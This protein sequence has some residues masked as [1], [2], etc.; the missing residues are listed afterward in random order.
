V[1][2]TLSFG[3]EGTCGDGARGR[4]SNPPVENAIAPAGEVRSSTDSALARIVVGKVAR[5]YWRSTSPSKID[6]DNA[7]FMGALAPSTQPVPDQQPLIDITEV[8]AAV[9][10]CI[11]VVGNDLASLSIDLFDWRN[12][13]KPVKI[14][15]HAAIELWRHIN[16][17]WTPALFF[18]HWIGD[19][20]TCGEA[21]SFFD[22]ENGVPFNVLRM[23]PQRVVVVPDPV[24]MIRGYLYRDMQYNSFPFLPEEIMH[25]RTANLNSPF[26]GLPPIG[27]LRHALLLEQEMHGFQYNRFKQGIPTDM[28][29]ETTRQWADEDE[30]EKFARKVQQRFAGAHNAGKPMVFTKG[31][32]DITLLPR[33][34]DKELAFLASLKF[35]RSE[36]AMLYG[37]PPVKLS[38]YSDAFRANSETQERSY[39]E[40]TVRSWARMLEEWWNSIYLKRF[41]PNE[42][43]RLKFNFDQVRALQQS[44]NEIA[45]FNTKGVQ[46]GWLSPNEARK[47]AGLEAWADKVADQLYYNGRKLG[48][49]PLAGVA[50]KLLQQ[51]D[52]EDDDSEQIQDQDSE[53]IQDQQA[54]RKLRLLTGKRS[55]LDKILDDKAETARLAARVRRLLREMYRVAGEEL[56][57]IAGIASA[58]FRVTDPTVLLYIERQSINLAGHWTE[59]T[60]EKLRAVLGEGVAT[61]KGIVQMRDNLQKAFEERREDWQLDRIARTETHEAHEAA[62]W[63]AAK[64]NEIPF[65]QWTTARDDRVRD[66]H[67]ALE[68]QIV[69]MD[70]SFADPDTGA[71]YMFPGDATL[72][73]GPEDIINCRCVWVAN[74]ESDDGERAVSDTKAEAAW[75]RAI[76]TLEV[77]EQSMRLLF[78][79]HTQEMERRVLTAFDE[80]AAVEA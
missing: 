28:V 11:D 46:F 64:Q 36:I 74:T 44:A 53:Q 80:V 12:P 4:V 45:D 35:T 16:P 42:K 23:Q 17:T 21:I 67:A 33:P 79:L 40:D 69:R 38:D 66:G 65:K 43:L 76:N 52:Q 55:L 75:F 3:W 73:A 20:F 1:C 39:W 26:R 41:W 77:F 31:E 2:A 27:R 14:E 49:D 70:D 24:K 30:I 54:E 57:D 18:Q 62:G 5:S 15:D 19:M 32:F 58:S 8:A 13:Q 59:T 7:Q 48:E 68:G 47:R 63:L 34:S 60:V 37:V 78:K 22:I 56:L 25:T 51:G 72:G 9:G 6:S 71:H 61:G 50:A 10:R 29:I